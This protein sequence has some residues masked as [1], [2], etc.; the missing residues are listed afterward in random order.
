MQTTTTD[1]LNINKV[2]DNREYTVSEISLY[3][4]SAIEYKFGIVRIRG[5]VSGLKVASSGHVYFNLKDDRAVLCCIC[6]K[7]AISRINVKIEDGIEIIAIGKLTIYS[8]QSRYQLLV[9]IVEAGGVGTLM[10]VF[11]QRKEKLAK[12]GL[13]D[14]SRK[15]KLP[16]FPTIIGVVTSISGAVIRDI[17][18]RINDRFPSK[19]LIWPVTVQGNNAANEIA[20]AIEGFNNILPSNCDLKPDII[21]VARGGGSVE[22]LWAFNEEIVV[23]SI[24]NSAI[25]IISAVG[26]EVDFTLADFAADIRSPTPTAAAEIAVPVLSDIKNNVTNLVNSIVNFT[27]NN[28][29]YNISLLNSYANIIQTPNLFINF[30]YQSL[31]EVSFRFIESIPRFLKLKKQ[32]LQNCILD[33]PSKLIQLHLLKLENLNNDLNQLI[34]R[35]LTNLNHRLY[36]FSSLLASMDY[37]KVLKRGFAVIRSVE[38]GTIISSSSQLILNKDIKIE[39]KDGIKLAKII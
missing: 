6:W 8:G 34:G 35:V 36:L 9:D 39:L 30:Y 22:D 29:K 2:V 24:A 11:Y 19:I 4:K 13:F 14:N 32:T 37:I 21:I 3:I 15:K 16:P 27:Y 23:R 10:Q 5:E 33:N 38:K 31:D 25:P 18:H 20:V 7:S 26:H 17:A 28:L 1:D 12:E